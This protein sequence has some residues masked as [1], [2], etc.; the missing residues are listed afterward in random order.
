MGDAKVI[1][2]GPLL[3][4]LIV[5]CGTCRGTPE[6]IPGAGSKVCECQSIIHL[7]QSG[8]TVEVN[9]EVKEM[10]GAIRQELKQAVAALTTEI[11]Q[12]NQTCGSSTSRGDPGKAVH[13][14]KAGEASYFY[15]NDCVS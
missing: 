10:L 9:K 13:P 12:L 7:G 15:I 6:A 2:V 8:S 14:S 5:L 4:M 1:L 3:L 11:K